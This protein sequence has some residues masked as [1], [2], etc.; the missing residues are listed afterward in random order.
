MERADITGIVFCGGEGRRFGGAL[1]PLAD[2]RGQPLLAHVLARLAPQVSRVILSAGRNADELKAFG[3]ETIA[4]ATPSAGPL[5]GLA[6]TL[7]AVRSEWVLTCPA[8]TPCLPKNLVQLLRGDAECAGVAVPHDGSRRQNLF[9]LMRRK[10]ALALAGFFA[11]GG[12]AIHRWL[13]AEDIHATDLSQW[14]GAFRNVN[15]PTE[16]AALRAEGSG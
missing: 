16:L 7:P 3:L 2:L 14:A 11:T 10:R 12:R 13:D 6:A 8:D 15:S 4:D 1:K 5:G 9:L